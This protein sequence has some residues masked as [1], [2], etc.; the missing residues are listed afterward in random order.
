MTE[1]RIREIAFSILSKYA[2]SDHS[3]RAVW[4]MA[5]DC[6]TRLIIPFNRHPLAIRMAECLISSCSDYR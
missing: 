3:G 1:R 6:L 5:G 2:H 4:M